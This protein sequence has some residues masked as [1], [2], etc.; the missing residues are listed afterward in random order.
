MRVRDWSSDVCSSDLLHQGRPDGG[1]RQAEPVDPR[2]ESGIV[3]I[4]EGAAT[5][6]PTVEPRDPGGRGLP[7][8]ERPQAAADGGAGRLE[9]EARAAGVRIRRAVERRDGKEG[10]SPG[11]S[12]WAP[13]HDKKK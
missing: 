3:E 2:A 11:R 6:G 9:Q 5:G 12:R 10:G 7:W 4:E 8:H 13:D 1:A